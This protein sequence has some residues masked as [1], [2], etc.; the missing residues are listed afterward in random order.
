M[1]SDD[2]KLMVRSTIFSELFLKRIISERLSYEFSQGLDR[3]SVTGEENK[4]P[5]FV[6]GESFRMFSFKVF[7]NRGLAMYINPELFWAGGVPRKANGRSA[8]GIDGNIRRFVP[9][10]RFLDGADARCT[11]GY[12]EN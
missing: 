4:T 8:F 6:I 3:N 5:R 10:Q 12:V 1:L 9:S 11:G 7:N 2:N